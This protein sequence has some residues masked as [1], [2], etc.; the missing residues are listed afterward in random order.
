MGGLS[1]QASTFDEPVLFQRLCRDRAFSL[2]SRA[3]AFL[4]STSSLAGIQ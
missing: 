3:F 1:H 4:L 2:R